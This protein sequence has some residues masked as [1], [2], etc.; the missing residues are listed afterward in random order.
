MDAMSSHPCAD[1]SCD[2]C[3][4]CDVVGVCCASVSRE[5][6]AQLE[7]SR[8]EPYAGLAATIVQ[9]AGLVP[10]LGE[11]V[12]RSHDAQH[13][14]EPAAPA[15]LAPPSVSNEHFPNDSRK[16]ASRVLSSR[17]AR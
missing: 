2:H 6:R 7:A 16:E 15:L 10:S 17:P 13:S 14:H 3:Y 8:V 4:L 11:L 5:Q 12:R 9:E 1:H